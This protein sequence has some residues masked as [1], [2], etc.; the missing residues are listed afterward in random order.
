MYPDVYEK[1][2]A[3]LKEHKKRKPEENGNLIKNLRI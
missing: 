1:R 2:F 3:L